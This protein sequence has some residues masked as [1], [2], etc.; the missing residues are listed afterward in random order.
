MKIGEHLRGGETIELV[1]DLGGGKT[2]FTKGLAKGAGSSD[3]VASPTFTISKVYKAPKFDIHHFDFYRLPDAGLAA[4]EV[5]DLIGDRSIVIV[6][7]WSGVI[8]H[9]LP[10]QRLTL[11]ISR[12][13]DNT[14]VI[15]VS[16]PERLEYLL[17]GAC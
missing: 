12:T 16:Y 2:T 4:H 6:S 13:G 11:R 7:E 9:I 14:R 3:V 15:E 5:E 10:E 8:E 1:S 17:E